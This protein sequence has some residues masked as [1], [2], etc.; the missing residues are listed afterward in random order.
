LRHSIAIVDLRE[1]GSTA[2]AMLWRKGQAPE[3]LQRRWAKERARAGDEPGPRDDVHD[4]D[5]GAE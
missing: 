2:I 5:D 1:W 3:R 4:A